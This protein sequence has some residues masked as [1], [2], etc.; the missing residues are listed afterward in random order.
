MMD[1]V[2]AAIA[3]MRATDQYELALAARSFA[4]DACAFA[5]GGAADDDDDPGFRARVTA[6]LAR[7]TRADVPGAFARLVACLWGP[8]AVVPVLAP[9]AFDD[10]VAAIAAIQK[11]K[12]YFGWPFPMPDFAAVLAPF[13]ATGHDIFT[14]TDRIT[15]RSDTWRFGGQ[16]YEAVLYL[17]HPAGDRVALLYHG[18]SPA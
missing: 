8:A 4:P 3:A 16:Q 12:L 7:I 6:D 11:C 18:A 17:V 13:V 9:C 10:A 2:A 1:P 14:A 15:D 5:R